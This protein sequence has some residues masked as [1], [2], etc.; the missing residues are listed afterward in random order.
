MR[1]RL[2]PKPSARTKKVSARG[3][4]GRSQDLLAEEDVFKRQMMALPGHVEERTTEGEAALDENDEEAPIAEGLLQLPN[5]RGANL[6]SAYMMRHIHSEHVM[7]LSPIEEMKLAQGEFQ[8][9]AAINMRLAMSSVASSMMGLIH[10]PIHSAD[11]SMKASTAVTPI[12][13]PVA[14]PVRKTSAAQA[15][16]A[17]FHPSGV[18]KHPGP[19]IRSM[20]Q[21]TIDRLPEDD[22]RRLSATFNKDVDNMTPQ[23]A[24]NFVEDAVKTE[25]IIKQKANDRKV[26][27]L[28]WYLIHPVGP[29]RL[30]W[31]VVSLV[32]LLYTATCTPLQ[33]SFNSHLDMVLLAKLDMSI[34]GFFLVDL[35]LNCFSTYEVR[36]RV[37]RRLSRIMHTYFRT[38][39]CLDVVASFPY[40]VLNTY[41]LEF[42]DGLRL[43]KLLRLARL[44]RILTRLEYSLL[45]KSTVSGLAKFF[46]L[47]MMTSHFF[48]CGFYK[49]S[50]GDTVHGWV[51]KYRLGNL[52]LYDKYVTCFYWSIMTMTTVGYGDVT[53]QTTSERVWSI[54]AM[55]NGAW[56]FAYGITNVVS[57]VSNL[58]MAD[59]QFQRKMD[60]VNKYMDVRDLPLSLRSEIRE[61]FFNTRITV[62]TKLKNE[63]KILS[64]LS[65]LLRSKVALAINDSVLNKMPFFEGADHNF[66]MEL[67]LSMKMVC[68]PPHEEVIIEGEIGEEM[69]FIFRGAVEVINGGQQV[70]VLG[71]KQYFGEMAILNQNCLRTATV[72]TLCFCELRMLTRERFLLALTHY[73]GMRQKISTIIRRRSQAVA[74]VAAAAA[75]SR[76][77]ST[78]IGKVIVQKKRRE[79]QLAPIASEN[80]YVEPKHGPS[81]SFP[82][83]QGDAAVLEAVVDAAAAPVPADNGSVTPPSSYVEDDGSGKLTTDLT[84]PS[85][86]PG[87]TMDRIEFCQQPVNPADAA[88]QQ[89]LELIQS[90][91]ELVNHVLLVH[92]KWTHLQSQMHL[93]HQEL[94]FYRATYGTAQRDATFS[95]LNNDDYVPPLTTAVAVSPA[96]KADYDEL[97]SETMES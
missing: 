22:L 89:I 84:E 54:F 87:S 8:A 37:E 66:L 9:K 65:A 28:P 36:G 31:D 48:S 55:V 61:F 86:N 45:L 97:T 83:V 34:D 78:S 59:T 24:L 4:D 93:M 38:W 94:A 58:N 43:L 91:D 1:P 50:E 40:N 11:T 12:T 41:L 77:V 3:S 63:S 20:Q 16:L 47:V 44:P 35:C 71:E 19:H 72:M 92:D 70:A 33:L 69:F 13:H 23:Q 56:I 25:N 7:G 42:N 21:V 46:I 17:K 2:R 14:P 26:K 62:D 64:E 79:P 75:A 30:R 53:G 73:P 52:T 95:K 27:K 49:I 29:F 60:F 96:Y 82:D 6:Q 68:M 85:L 90:Q 57:M 18:D 10:P 51:A 81:M 76:R 5:G 74:K 80:S 39:F 67:A 88:R 15:L 32:L